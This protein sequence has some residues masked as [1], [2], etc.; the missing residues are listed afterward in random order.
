[1]N[2]GGA[3]GVCSACHTDNGNGPAD[4][5]KC[6]NRTKMDDKHK[7]INNYASRCLECHPGGRGD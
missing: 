5:F 7:N 6:H 3:N 1:M 2:H 4:C